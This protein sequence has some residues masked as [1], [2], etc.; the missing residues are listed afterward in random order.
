VAIV[1][2]IAVIFLNPDELTG[3]D[4]WLNILQSVQLP[5]ALIPLIKFGASEK[6]MGVFA[7]PKWQVYFSIIF[8]VL[9]FIMNFVIVFWDFDWSVWYV[10]VIVFV[11]III[12]IGL[13]LM[14]I[15]EPCSPLK[16]MSKEE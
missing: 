4:T 5:F 7:L 15:R 11:V 16:K 12:Y 3:M 8:A 1:P 14:A 10:V 9:L 2:A 6:V 13:I